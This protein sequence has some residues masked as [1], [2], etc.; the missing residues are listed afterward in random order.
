M[1]KKR[2]IIAGMLMT[3]CLG[4]SG[5][6]A[7]YQDSVSVQ[8]HI[9]TGDVNIGIQEYQEIDGKET[10]YDLAEN[11]IVLPS[12]VVSKIP[13]ITNYAETCYLRAKVTHHS[14]PVSDSDT[15]EETEYILSDENINGISG[16][17]I[18]K[19]EY[20]YY[21]EPLKHGASVDFFEAVTIPAE[22]TE[23]SSGTSLG[24]TVTA[25]AIQAANFTPDFQSEQPWGDQK[26][27]IC[28]HEEDN[29]IT[30]VN[31][32]YQQ[33]T[34]T[35][36]GAARNL[37]AVPEDFFQ[38]LDKA[39][40][41]DTVQDTFSI[42]NTTD[43]E[44]EFFF[45]TET[46]GGLT[47]E[48]LD[49]LKQ[50]Q[51]TILQNGTPIYSGDLEAA[52]LNSRISLGTYQPGEEGSIHFTLTLPAELKNAYAQRETYINWIFSVEG[53][54]E[55]VDTPDGPAIDQM[56]APKTGLANPY[57]TIPLL[58]AAAA[59]ISTVLLSRRKE[60]NLNHEMEK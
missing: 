27:E 10:E 29:S 39:M 24:V 20:Y 51:L 35:Y 37:I 2:M 14:K 7:Y 60:G 54:E 42:S 12:E 45:Q 46:P 50:F 59:G 52:S 26:I 4:I 36:E 15:E 28:V 22:W 44:A 30:E 21:T 49:L 41:G 57:V 3:A 19:G 38:N 55:I 47:E 31:Q 58:L 9:N 5:T 43:T 1:K 40:P 6:Y 32:E 13:R 16:Q 56:A 11:R 25:E 53:A 23:A 34:V 48:E 8:N 18:R 17:W 33:M